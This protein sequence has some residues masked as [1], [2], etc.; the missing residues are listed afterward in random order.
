MAAIT[1]AVALAASSLGSTAAAPSC[2]APR[3]W[4]AWHEG[5]IFPNGGDVNILRLA[6]GG[7]LFWNGY[8]LGSAGQLDYVF[9]DLAKRGN[10][11]LILDPGDADC[12]SVH[13]IALLAEQ[14]GLCTSGACLFGSPPQRMVPPPVP[15]YRRP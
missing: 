5:Q 13:D 15:A 12:A 6:S 9:K 10:T 14:F 4:A 8:E 1:T 7:H 11:N 3:G 2:P